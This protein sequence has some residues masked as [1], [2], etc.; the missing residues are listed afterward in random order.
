MIPTALNPP[1]VIE[2]VIRKLLLPFQILLLLLQ[3]QLARRL[4]R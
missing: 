3:Q 1:N 2:Q 4:L